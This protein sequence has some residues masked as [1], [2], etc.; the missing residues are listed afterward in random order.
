MGWRALVRGQRCACCCFLP[1][2]PSPRTGACCPCPQIL[3][4][5]I[6]AEHV[7]QGDLAGHSCGLGSSARVHTCGPLYVMCV[8]HVSLGVCVCVYPYPVPPTPPGQQRQVQVG[9]AL[10][11]TS[12]LCAGPC[13]RA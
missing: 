11:R 5:D 13:G 10:L 12:S 8:G 7:G 6:E 3:F 2:L 1:S 9:T 4:R